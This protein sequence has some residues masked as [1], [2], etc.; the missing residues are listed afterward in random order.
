MKSTGNLGMKTKNYIIAAVLIMI[1]TAIATVLIM[2]SKIDYKNQKTPRSTQVKSKHDKLSETVAYLY[3]TNKTGSHL[4]AEERVILRPP[5][6]EGFG[7]V[8]IEGLIKGPAT[9]FVRTLPQE[10][11]VRAFF[12]TQD[13]TAVIDLSETVSEKH[14]GG[15]QSEY[16]SIYSIVNSIVLNIPEI[17][18]V[19]ILIGGR[20]AD[21]LAGHIDIRSPFKANMLLVR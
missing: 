8:I 18:T 1:A 11:K 21:T 13:S 5:E 17:E 19:K 20:E 3:F 14:P 2:N 10:T 16:L 15:S 9:G 4:T 6:P 12:I 7:N